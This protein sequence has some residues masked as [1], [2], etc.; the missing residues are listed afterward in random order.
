[1][2]A[3]TNLQCV[4]SYAIVRTI[5]YILIYGTAVSVVLA[6]LLTRAT[7]VSLSLTICHQKAIT[8]LV[9]S[10]YRNSNLAGRQNFCV[11]LGRFL[12]LGT[13]PLPQELLIFTTFV[14][15]PSR[16]IQMPPQESKLFMLLVSKCGEQ[17]SK[18]QIEQRCQHRNL[19]LPLFD[20]K[21]SIHAPNHNTVV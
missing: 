14:D 18:N 13:Q 15:R 9:R 21:K 12:L 7:R 5:F 4:D 17:A 1:M 2:D 20:S 8:F 16:S 6:C 3:C 19:C 10:Q 11:L